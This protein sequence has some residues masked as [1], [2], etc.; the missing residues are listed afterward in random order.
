MF[1]LTT[2]NLLAPWVILGILALT[3]AAASG[4][5]FGLVALGVI[6]MPAFVPAV[7]AFVT[8]S[9]IWGAVFT[10]NT[11][12]WAGVGLLSFMALYPLCQWEPVN[13]FLDKLTGVVVGPVLGALSALFIHNPITCFIGA[14]DVSHWKRW[15]IPL[16]MCRILI[17]PIVFPVM[18]LLDHIKDG[19]KLGFKYGFVAAL[20]VPEKAWR[21]APYHTSEILLPWVAVG[22]AGTAMIGLL[23]AGVFTLSAAVAA[24]IT[25]ITAD[26]LLTVGIATAATA[27]MAFFYELAQGLLKTFGGFFQKE[28]AEHFPAF[29]TKLKGLL[30]RTESV[31]VDDGI[32][33][34][35]KVTG[36]EQDVKPLLRKSAAY[37]QETPT[38]YGEFFGL[39]R[40]LSATDLQR[41]PSRMPAEKPIT[42]Y[43]QLSRSV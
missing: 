6:A 28:R 29:E 19:F 9:A 33:S 5:I 35:E 43:V 8:T 27:T 25:V 34:S 1:G 13:N 14:L 38:K 11:L 15:G 42:Y 41:A 18:A 17:S 32:P 22:L 37:F 7:I 40:D 26:T 10:L 23:A 3:L 2:A 12:L 31:T 4:I 24:V 36:L 21:C 16:N 30:S 39:P 20:Q